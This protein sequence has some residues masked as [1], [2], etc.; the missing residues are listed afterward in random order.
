MKTA[1]MMAFAL[2]F[3]A[4]AFAQ[5][6]S[7]PTS[8]DS[9]KSDKGA[10]LPFKLQKGQTFTYTIDCSGGMA[11]GMG[12]TGSET[13]RAP[14]SG[15]SAGMAGLH[16]PVVYKVDVVDSTSGITTLSVAVDT[17][18]MTG[19]S[20]TGSSPKGS[21]SEPGSSSSTTG[22]SSA[23]T[24]P[25]EQTFTVKCDSSGRIQEILGPGQS[26]MYEKNRAAET[27][28]SGAMPMAG[29]LPVGQIGPHIALI[30]GSGLHEGT[31]EPGRTY[32]ENTSKLDSGSM[33]GS[34]PSASGTSTTDRE[35]S[36]SSMYGQQVDLQKL[37]MRVEGQGSQEGQDVVR[38]SI[39]E[40]GAG[41]AGSAGPTGSTSSETGRAT[42][43]SSATMGEHTLGQ[44]YYRV[45]DGLLQSCTID[46][47][48]PESTGTG[49]SPTGSTSGSSATG[50]GTSKGRITIR[51]LSESET[52]RND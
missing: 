15:S 52:P 5:V 8:S 21:T 26:P 20:K 27:G 12:T 23:T 44:A 41:S 36:I 35:R 47:A 19:G 6:E 2:M 11:T 14:A 37:R 46:L 38:L 43:G 48:G 1:M 32:F 31:L 28:K 4:G 25:C 30:L 18:G 16:N 39:L 42:S 17:Q 49:A 13:G 45:S 33:S 51:R 50:V 10:R 9:S 24:A 34:S 7:K 40:V 22:S 3:A 29:V